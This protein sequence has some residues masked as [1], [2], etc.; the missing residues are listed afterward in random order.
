[1]ANY[2]ANYNPSVDPSLDEATFT[3]EEKAE[4]Y[5]TGVE[6]GGRLTRDCSS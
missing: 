1:M 2:D 4:D 6:G 5:T 3:G